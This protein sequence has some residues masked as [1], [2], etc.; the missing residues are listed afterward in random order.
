MSQTTAAPAG[1]VLPDLETYR[2]NARLWLEKSMERRVGPPEHHEVDYYTPQV[3]EANR[4][5][6]RR[7]CD[8]GYAGISFP[9]E[10]G[11]QGLPL[12][13]DAAFDEAALAMVRRSDPVP[14][15]PPLVADEGLNF[16]LPVIFRVKGRS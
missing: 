13:Y 15:P 11:G 1:A 5:L 16:T 2:S 10:Y 14:Q 8:A 6:Q 9:K 7:L 4:A 3:I 12:S